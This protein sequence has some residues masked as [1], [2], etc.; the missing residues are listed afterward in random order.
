MKRREFLVRS[1][2]ACAALAIIPAAT[3]TSCSGAKGLALTAAN[4]MVQV[5]LAQLDA[6]GNTVVKAK[7]APEDFVIMKNADGTYEAIGLKCTHKGGPVKVKDGQLVCG[8]H[9]STFNTTGHVTKGPAKDDLP[10]YKTEMVGE[11][12]NVKFA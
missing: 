10:R 7:G 5:P 4:G 3:L 9:G 11:M 6:S 2:Q 1:C 12:L 8:W